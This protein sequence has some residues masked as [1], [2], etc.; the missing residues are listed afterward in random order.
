MIR[1]CTLVALTALV[2]LGLAAPGTAS[3]DALAKK[4]CKV[5]VKVVKGKKRK[6]R[7]CPKPKPPKKI[8]ISTKPNPVTVAPRV[9]QSRSASGTIGRAGGS[10]TATAANGN[11]FTLAVQKDA[12]AEDTAIALTPVASIQKLPLSGGLIAAVRLQPEGLRFAKLATLTITLGRSVSV[13]RQIAF[14]AED[15]G[16]QFHLY[17][18]DSQPKMITLR[19]A[20]FTIAGAGQGT[21]QDA[22][23]AAQH[24]PSSGEA[25]AEQLGAL[26]QKE[27]EAQKAGKPSPFKKG[28]LEKRLR[29]VL[30]GLYQQRVL[31]DMQRAVTSTDEAFVTA[32]VQ[33]ALSW[34]RTVQ[35]L[36]GEDEFSVEQAKLMELIRA[37]FVHLLDVV[38]QRC[39]SGGRQLAFSESLGWLVDT[40]TPKKIIPLV[41]QA[42]LLFGDD[43]PFDLESALRPCRPRG[44]KFD[45]FTDIGSAETYRQE[46]RW[47]GHV[48]AETAFGV[49]WQGLSVVVFYSSEPVPSE[50]RWVFVPGVPT[51]DYFS[52]EQAGGNVGRAF[53]YYYDIE[54]LAAQLRV[55]VTS[56]S[57]P[58]DQT[59]TVE[60]PLEEDPSC[61]A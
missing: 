30:A 49:P 27:Q 47:T 34:I 22:G 56:N 16:R 58:F 57:G 6:V 50:R 20:H 19:L 15:S 9:D 38:K 53:G 54:L 33:R 40:A 4:K 36:L 31:P 2:A 18:K 60:A 43:P 12:L 44:F 13:Q 25:Q 32:A 48:C 39:G 55:R 28:E 10:I 3:T 21:M 61:P 35:L 11:S 23:R 5:V 46:K 51:R 52:D 37:S 17:P 7:V 41:R 14:A 45:V 59:F 1:L 29:G 42:Q 26:L 8:P 24:P